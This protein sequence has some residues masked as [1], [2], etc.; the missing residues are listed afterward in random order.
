MTDSG[1]GN[2][3]VGI[4][5]RGA[6]SIAHSVMKGGR[7][8]MSEDRQLKSEVGIWKSEFLELGT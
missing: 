1:S 5:E 3:E 6:E 8:Q 2:L 7:G 4:L